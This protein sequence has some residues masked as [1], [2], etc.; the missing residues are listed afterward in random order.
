[1]TEPPFSKPGDLFLSSKMGVIDDSAIPTPVPIWDQD[2]PMTIDIS[3][4]TRDFSC[5]IMTASEASELNSFAKSR[6]I[7]VISSRV[8]SIAGEMMRWRT[9][10][11]FPSRGVLENVLGV[12]FR[13]LDHRDGLVFVTTKHMVTETAMAVVCG[14]TEALNDHS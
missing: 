11:V 14:D 7:S 13:A 3:S 10:N 1:M 2:V 6:T 5:S 4:P 9:A 12:L 8:V